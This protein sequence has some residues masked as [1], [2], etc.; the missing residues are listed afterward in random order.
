MSCDPQTVLTIVQVMAAQSKFLPTVNQACPSPAYS[1]PSMS[2]SVSSLQYTRPVPACLL[3]TVHQ[4]CPCLS[5]PYSTPG[6]SLSTFSLQYTRPVPV[7]LL[8]TVYQVLPCL[9]PPYST[10]GLSW[11]DLSHTIFLSMLGSIRI[12]GSQFRK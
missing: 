10:P 6:L 2:L 8:P 4:T 3:P 5:L 9:S 11:P 12:E 1:T 7:C